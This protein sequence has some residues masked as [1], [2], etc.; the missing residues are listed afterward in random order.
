MVE[1]SMEEVIII[2]YGMGNIDSVKRSVEVCNNIPS[3]TNDFQ[4]ILNAKHIILPGVGNFFQASHNIEQLGLDKILT[5]AVIENGIP[6]L[7]ICL[8]MQLMARFGYE[9]GTSN[10]LGWIDA[11]V[12]Q[13]KSIKK[14]E[15]IPHI[16]WNQIE[17]NKS[18]ALLLN[19]P[20]GS[21]FYFVHSYYVEC[22]NKEDIIATT[23]YIG[24]FPSII[25]KKK[26]YGVQ[27]HPEKSQKFGLQLIKNFLSI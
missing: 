12:I 22:N 2:N 21:D 14:D 9:G 1:S 17:Y 13:M 27:F 20:S 26:F 25:G 18:N 23:P 5:K 3:I 19:I 16:G 6:F 7:G 11:K 10:G 8:G 4:R 15:K 24:G